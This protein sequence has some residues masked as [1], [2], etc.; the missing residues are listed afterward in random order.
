MLSQ[1]SYSWVFRRLT[2]AGLLS[3]YLVSFFYNGIVHVYEHSHSNEHVHFDNCESD[4]CHLT[5]FHPNQIGGCNHKAHITE[6]HFDC[7][8]CND[9]LVLQIV[10]DNSV[11]KSFQPEGTSRLDHY[12]AHHPVSTKV[13]IFLRGPPQMI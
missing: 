1:L 9:H 3:F 2:A 10:V 11:T 13:E 6:P 8:G 4:A 12:Y 7:F 5:L